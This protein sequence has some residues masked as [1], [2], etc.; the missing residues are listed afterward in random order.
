MAGLLDLFEDTGGLLDGGG[1]D[2]GLLG[3]P[4]RRSAYS[5]EAP[6][7]HDYMAGPTLICP[8]ALGCTAPEIADQLARFGVPGRDPARPV[9]DGERS[10]VWHPDLPIPA[11]HV[12]SRIT[13][14]GLTI[15]NTTEPGHVFH[16]GHIMR[17]ATQTPEG[18]WYV[19]TRGTGNN[20]YPLMQPLNTWQGPPIFRSLDERLRENIRRHHG[21][22]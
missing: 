19:T 12:T 15:T 17:W 1:D 3:S 13:D 14:D 10:F 2:A 6:G 9:A 18:D 5:P 22:P 8:S 20:R 11:G 4:R 21:A 7:W 16:D